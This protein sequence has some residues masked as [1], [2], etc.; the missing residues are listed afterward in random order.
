[1]RF[2]FDID[3]TLINLREYAFHLYNEMLNKKIDISVFQN[4][5]TVEIH[6]PFGLTKEEG[7]KLWNSL[8]EDIYFKECPPFPFAVEILNE[9]VDSGHEVYYITARK[10]EFAEQTKQWMKDAGFPIQDNHFYC[11]MEDHEKLPIIHELKLDY[12]FDDKPAVLE[13]LQDIPVQFFVRN[14][15]YNKAYNWN[16]INNWSELRQLIKS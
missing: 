9:L 15:S 12:Y 6:E 10:K 4:L 2:G 16:R 11:G 13:T 8:R 3:D 5:E 1:M 7:K 14:Q